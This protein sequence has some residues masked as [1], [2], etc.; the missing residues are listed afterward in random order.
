M[1][2]KKASAEVKVAG[3][4]GPVVDDEGTLAFSAA[5]L[6][7]Y[8]LAQYKVA[9][10]AQ[11]IALKK[12]DLVTLEIKFKETVYKMQMDIAGLSA[13][14]KIAQ[15]DLLSIQTDLARVYEVDLGKVSYDDT[16][17]KIFQDG[18]PLRRKSKQ[19]K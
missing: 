13:Q 7:K 17:G 3:I 2:K 12:S 10:L 4:A 15:A 1:A 14:S 9:N 19:H 6:A 5:D 8:E 16:S 11:G 18:E